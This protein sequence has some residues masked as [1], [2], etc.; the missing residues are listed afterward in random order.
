MAPQ[1]YR[2]WRREGGQFIYVPASGD[3]WDEL[4]ARLQLGQFLIGTVVWVPRPGVIGIGVDLGLPVGGFVDVL[5]LPNDIRRWPKVGLASEFEVWW[6]DEQPQIRL[7]PVGPRYRCEEFISWVVGR[8][9]VAAAAFC[10]RHSIEGL[11]W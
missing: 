8:E 4:K 2:P 1:E 11:S 5:L 7:L 3:V 10:Q 9:T 6:M